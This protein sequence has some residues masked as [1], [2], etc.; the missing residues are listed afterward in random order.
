MFDFKKLKEELNQHRENGKKLQDKFPSYAKD[1]LTI[2]F[3]E[4][5]SLMIT[6]CSGDVYLS[7]DEGKALLDFF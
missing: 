5:A 7:F 6:K 1:N 4:N 2:D 3:D